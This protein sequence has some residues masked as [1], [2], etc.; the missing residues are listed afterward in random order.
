[1]IKSRIPLTIPAN[2]QYSEVA[3][4]EYGTLTGLLVRD[5]DSYP[6]DGASL[7]SLDGE[8][9]RPFQDNNGR[10]LSVSNDIAAGHYPLYGESYRSLEKVRFVCA[11]ADTAVFDRTL[12]L[13]LGERF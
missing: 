3:S 5:A 1:M 11:A 9:W 8:V 6:G 12:I 10:M 7:E 2:E 13:C 4:L